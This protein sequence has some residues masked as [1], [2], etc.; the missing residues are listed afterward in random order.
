LRRV[1]RLTHLALEADMTNADS[2]AQ[3]CEAGPRVA[4]AVGLAE[5]M[6]PA[7]KSAPWSVN[8]TL[9]ALMAA[10]GGLDE[11]VR[12][13][14]LQGRMTLGALRRLLA[15]TARLYPRIFARVRE[16]FGV[17]GTLWWIAGV[18]EAVWSERRS[19]AAAARGGDYASE[20]PAREFA[21]L[22]ASYGDGAGDTL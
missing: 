17:R 10:L 11:R 19:R 9:N 2:L 21:R 14:L 20:D 5:F 16:H 12:R 1:A 13:E 4:R 7:P 18:A 6:R 3:L 15:R 8:E 22:A